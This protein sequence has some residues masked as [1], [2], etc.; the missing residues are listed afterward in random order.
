MIKMTASGVFKDLRGFPRPI[1]RGGHNIRLAGQLTGFYEIEWFSVK[2]V[3]KI[4]N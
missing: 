3:G 4:L 2:G 1:G